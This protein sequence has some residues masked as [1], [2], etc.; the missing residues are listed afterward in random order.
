[1]RVAMVNGD[2]DHGTNSYIDKDTKVLH[3][4]GTVVDVHAFEGGHQMPPPPV[5]IK[6]LRWLLDRGVPGKTAP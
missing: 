4:A 1:M 5:Q 2:K 3:R 6:A